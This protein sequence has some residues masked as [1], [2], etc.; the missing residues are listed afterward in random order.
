MFGSEGGCLSSQMIF[1]GG[2]IVLALLIFYV[3]GRYARKF[4][5]GRYR[6]GPA[7]PEHR[8]AHLDDGSDDVP[9]SHIP[10]PSADDDDDHHEL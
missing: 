7:K 10:L 3:A 9:Y 2:I 6:N 5:T 1:L 8:V 4:E